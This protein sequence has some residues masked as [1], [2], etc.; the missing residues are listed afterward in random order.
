MTSPLIFKKLSQKYSTPEKVQSFLR[1]LKYNRETVAETIRSAYVTYKKRE[2]HCLEACLLAA[3][4]LEHQGFPPLLLCLDSSDNLNH[5][6]FIYKTKT[7]WGAIGRSREPGLHGREPRFRSIRSLALS[8][9]DFFVDKTG[10]LIG[11]HVISLDDIGTNWR[12]SPRNVWKVDQMIVTKKYIK[13]S[14]NPKRVK[15]LRKKYLKNGPISA[16]KYWC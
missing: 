16:G 9:A 5:A 12:F 15:L 6:V 2:A 8:Y 11:Y 3:A 4:I 14:P 10:S 7:G 1:T 13:I